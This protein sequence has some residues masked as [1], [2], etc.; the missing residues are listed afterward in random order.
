MARH[1]ARNCPTKLEILNSKIML[2]MMWIH[3]EMQNII[4]WNSSWSDFHLIPA[5]RLLAAGDAGLETGYPEKICHHDGRQK[6]TPP[7]MGA[8]FSFWSFFID[9]ELKKKFR[10]ILL[11]VEFLANSFKA[12]D[13]VYSYVT[14]SGVIVCVWQKRENTSKGPSISSQTLYQ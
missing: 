3:S 5:R 7:F 12:Y 8:Q 1:M 10:D 4:I 14:P 6:H 11:Y 9:F 2:W 13:H